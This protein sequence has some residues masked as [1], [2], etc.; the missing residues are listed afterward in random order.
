MSRT[1]PDVSR[2]IEYGNKFLLLNDKNITSSKNKVN[3]KKRKQPERLS[4]L[5]T[6]IYK[7]NGIV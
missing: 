1:F 6:I 5:A 7:C 4:I 2:N 3:I